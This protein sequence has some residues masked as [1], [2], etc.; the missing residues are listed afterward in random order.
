MSNDLGKSELAIPCGVFLGEFG[1]Y[2]SPR[3]SFQIPSE[4][5]HLFCAPQS[6]YLSGL[7]LTSLQRSQNIKDLCKLSNVIPVS[8]ISPVINLVSAIKVR[9]PLSNL[10]GPI[11]TVSSP[12][13]TLEAMEGDILN[14]HSGLPYH[15]PHHQLNQYYWE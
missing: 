11:S 12:S 2:T 1:A 3:W 14:N 7:N 13:C 4:E 5:H 8:S 6:T 9:K 15:P 10:Q